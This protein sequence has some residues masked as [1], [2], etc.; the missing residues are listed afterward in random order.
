MVHFTAPI[1]TLLVAVS[2][3]SAHWRDNHSSNSTEIHMTGSHLNATAN[4][5]TRGL[6]ARARWLQQEYIDGHNN[7]RAKHGAKALIWDDGLSESAYQWALKC[8]FEHSQSGQ[9]L[10]AGTGGPT[11]ATA[12][13]WW[14]AESKDYNPA[15]PQYSHWTQVVWKSTT[16]FGCA[17]AECA[18]GT[19]FDAK[20]GVA[21]YF[22]C[23]Y[24][25][26]GNVIG[27]FAQNVQK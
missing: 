9:N 4:L 6:E 13:G 14:N 10:A 7:E 21:N 19:I 25:P 3:V 23:H 5:A 24:S 2:S 20:Y 17:R 1:F 27:Q 15:N 8:K 16:K 12:V 26:A 22:V 18:P 11:P